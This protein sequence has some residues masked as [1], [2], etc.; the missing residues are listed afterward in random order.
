MR[1]AAVL[2]AGVLCLSTAQAQLGAATGALFIPSP[3]GVALTVGKWIYDAATRQQV[4][5]IEVAGHGTTVTEARQA[6]FRTAVE[7]ALGSLISSET[8]VTNG[9]VERDEIISYAAGFVDRWEAVSTTTDATGTTVTMRVWVRRSALADRLL[10]RTEQSGQIDGARASTQLQTINQ[11]RATGDR[12]LQ[13]VLDDFPRRAFDI[14]MEPAKVNRQN[15]SAVL[16][17]IFT[18]SWNQ[19]YLRSLWTALDATAQRRGRPVA[20]VTVAGGTL[21]GRWGGVAGFDD[22]HKLRL[23]AASMVGTRPALLVTVRG[24]ARE[25]LYT[26]CFN[27]QELDHEPDYWVNDQRFVRVGSNSAHIITNMRYRGQVQIPVNPVAL[28]SVTSID[29]DIV[30][31]DRCPR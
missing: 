13:T 19:D 20:T 25:S 31:R 15:R 24:S 10:G 27:L 5:Y 9:R 17:V 22:L 18:I 29:M 3:V 14:R 23:V 28:A 8:V 1:V 2:I 6:A 12:L 21:F 7:S 4:Y 30:T 16:D 26:A 11:E